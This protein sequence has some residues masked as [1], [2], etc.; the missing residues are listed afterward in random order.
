VNFSSYEAILQ[1][2]SEEQCW[3][4]AGIAALL[5]MLSRTYATSCLMR[6]QRTVHGWLYK[7]SQTQTH[8]HTP[9]NPPPHLCT[10]EQALKDWPCGALMTNAHLVKPVVYHY[11][12]CCMPHTAVP[13]D[14]GCLGELHTALQHSQHANQLFNK[15]DSLYT[16]VL[17]HS[18]ICYQGSRCDCSYG[19]LHHSHL[20]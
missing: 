18:G 9:T 6:L 20:H 7:H 1:P 12:G 11:P 17:A 14:Q 3:L 16:R 8:T 19:Y 2:L 10:F 15:A 13:G 5:I 4:D